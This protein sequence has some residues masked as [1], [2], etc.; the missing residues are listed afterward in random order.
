MA[1]RGRR[2]TS[3]AAQPTA[4]SMPISPEVNTWPARNTVSP[5][6]R[7]LPTKAMATSGEPSVAEGDLVE[8]FKDSRE[9]WVLLQRDLQLVQ[10]S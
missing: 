4:A 8:S 10:G 2:Q 9:P 5:R 1:T 7:S 3:T 6:A